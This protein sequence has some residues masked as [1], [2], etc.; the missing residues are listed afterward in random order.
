[1]RLNPADPAQGYIRLERCLLARQVSGRPICPGDSGACVLAA[2]GQ[3]YRF[4]GLLVGSRR[5]PKENSNEF[6]ICPMAYIKRAIANLGFA[7]LDLD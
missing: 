6:W 7:P 1:M 2:V 3:D 5:N 4:V